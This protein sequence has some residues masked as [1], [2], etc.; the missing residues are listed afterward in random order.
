MFTPKAQSLL[1]LVNDFEAWEKKMSI[2][3]SEGFNYDNQH[4]DGLDLIAPKGQLLKPFSVRLLRIEYT[5]P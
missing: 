2:D 3:N 1:D 4:L 5:L